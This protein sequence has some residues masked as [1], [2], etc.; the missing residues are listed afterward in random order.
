MGRIIEIRSA[1][2]PT[3]DPWAGDGPDRRRCPACA[4]LEPGAERCRRCKVRLVTRVDRR[5]PMT[6]NLLNLC[7]ILLGK[8]PMLLAI[9]FLYRAAEAPLVTPWTIWLVAQIPLLA[10][11]AAGLAM[12][13]RWPWY[14][15]LALAGIDL[16]AAVGFQLAMGGSPVLPIAAVLANLMILGLLLTVFDEV[17]VDYGPIDMP[18]A[19]TLPRTALDSYNAGVSYSNAGFWYLAARL[20]QRAVALEHHEGRYRRALGLAYMRLRELAAAEAELA[21]AAALMPDDSQTMQLRATLGALK[22]AP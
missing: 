5:R 19:D 18:P 8:G 6:A 9:G 21:A 4:L 2:L 15:A 14:L 7:V 17:R 12:R 3:P 11:A 13:W 22:K 1:P 16:L 20:W 10:L